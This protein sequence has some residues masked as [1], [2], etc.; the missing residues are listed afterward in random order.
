MYSI[1]L[2]SGKICPKAHCYWFPCDI[3][4]WTL[5]Q[6]HLLWLVFLQEFEP[7]YCLFLLFSGF[8]SSASLVRL[9]LICDLSS[10]D[11]FMFGAIHFMYELTC[12]APSLHLANGFLSASL[13]VPVIFINY[14][15]IEMGTAMAWWKQCYT[16]SIYIRI[17]NEC[18]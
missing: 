4:L 6:K 12:C 2:G 9:H 18:L 11:L 15:S 13:Q 17:Q 10:L 8:L 5:R 1:W 14:H 16:L 7:L 3:E